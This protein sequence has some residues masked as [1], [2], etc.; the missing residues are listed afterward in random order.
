MTKEQIE[1]LRQGDEDSF[2]LFVEDY[3]KLIVKI[4][5]N[6]LRNKE[7]AEDIAQ[8]VFVEVFKSINTF[9][10]EAQLSTWIYRIAVSKCIDYSRKMKSRKRFGMIKKV[11][12]LEQETIETPSPKEFNPANSLEEKE[13]LEI[14]K[15]A[16][17]KIPANQRI[18]LTLNKLEE[19]S[20]KE[21][22][23]IMG[24][25]ISAVESLIH[26]GKTN[27]RKQLYKYFEKI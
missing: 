5:F 24:T 27:L 8:D 13:R 20:H 26:R 9:R 22:A 7:D 4:C 3:Q 11:L 23:K 12:G 16:L 19:M 6:F 14:L 25:S 17:N 18:V 1:K 2:R 15:I 10:E 21:I